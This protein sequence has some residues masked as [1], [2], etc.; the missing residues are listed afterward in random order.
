MSTNKSATSVGR[1]NQDLNSRIDDNA[2][3][4][5]KGESRV[6]GATRDAV[7]SGSERTERALHHATDATADAAKR[8]SQSAGD[9][10]DKGRDQWDKGRA[11]AEEGLDTVMDY[12]RDNPG[13]S[14][15]MAVAGGWLLGAILRRRH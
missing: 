10:R 3:R 8:A 1:D 4:L 6:M 11:Q 2:E 12:V 5:K 7:A 9:L 15:A 14:V 13:K